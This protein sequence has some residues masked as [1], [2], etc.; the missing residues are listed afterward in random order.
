MSRDGFEGQEKENV[1][2]RWIFLIK[3]SIHLCEEGIV[4]SDAEKIS[5]SCKRNTI[6]VLSSTR[7]AEVSRETIATP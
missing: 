7:F 3:T 2:L 5:K 4:N 1:Q 6:D